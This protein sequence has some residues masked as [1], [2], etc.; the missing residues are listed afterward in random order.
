MSFIFICPECKQKLEAQDEWE[1]MELPCPFCHHTLK[2]EKKIPVLKPV[3]EKNEGQARE[4]GG[5]ANENPG[6]NHFSNDSFLFICPECGTASELKA[7]MN[8]KSFTCPACGEDVTAVP[9]LTRQCP[10]CGEEIKIKA[11]Y[12]KHC[13]KNIPPIQ[14]RNKKNNFASEKFRPE[15][16]ESAHSEFPWAWTYPSNSASSEKGVYIEKLYK[17]FFILS[18]IALP[19]ITFGFI[20]I[21]IWN[22]SSGMSVFGFLLL[23]IGAGPFIAYNVYLFMLIY[24]YWKLIPPDKAQTTPGKAVGFLF[25]PFFALYWGFIAYWGL[26]KAL[27]EETG[28]NNP[29]TGAWGLACAIV[30]CAGLLSYLSEIGWFFTLAQIITP[31]LTIQEFHKQARKLL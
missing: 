12:C 19:L 25:I 29:N 15:S 30:V 24:Q 4:S 26:G 18:S 27:M 21:N 28:E 6:E 31:A 14:P 7:G 9:S 23:F 10:H 13:H 1:G 5:N 11:V 16:R 22:T 2:I 8:G 3:F 20:I 17:N